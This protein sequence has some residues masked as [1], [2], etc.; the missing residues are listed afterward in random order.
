MSTPE[1]QGM[2]SKKLA[3]MFEEIKEKSIGIDSVT[4]VRN[5]YIV[6]D[7]YLGR[8]FKPGMKHIILSCSKSITS[9]LIGI[10]I[11][12][13]QF[14]SSGFLGNISGVSS[15]MITPNCPA[16]IYLGVYYDLTKKTTHQSLKRLRTP[17]PRIF[18]FQG[19]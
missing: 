5:G 3:D 13:P 12:Q 7:A 9:T 2:D 17:L 6:T 19:R 1:K 10:A 18:S 16:F 15:L 8:F 14:V 11:D 4:I